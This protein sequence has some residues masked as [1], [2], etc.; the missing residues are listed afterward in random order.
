VARPTVTRAACGLARPS[1]TSSSRICSCGAN[2]TFF[3]TG[4][5]DD[6]PLPP[7]VIYRALVEF[8]GF[9]C[10]LTLLENEF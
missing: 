10:P 1:A 6:S 2:N 9:T 8:A 5:V 7:A 4:K 3:D